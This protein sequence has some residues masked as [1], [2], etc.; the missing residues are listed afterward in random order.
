MK[1]KIIIG[2]MVLVIIGIFVSIFYFT[3]P[4]DDT[5]RLYVKC[6]D[7]KEEYDVMIGDEIKFAESDAKCKLEFEV[8][9]IDRGFIK[10]N[11]KTYFY[12]INGDKEIDRL[13]LDYDV[14][15]P[16]DSSVIL[17]GHDR[18]TRF[19]FSFK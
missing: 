3:R 19:E 17:V 4:I 11:S 13:T 5:K 15:V 16:T 10:L 8:V 14:Y 12:K 6:N 9:N 2:I 7:F 18:E 1:K